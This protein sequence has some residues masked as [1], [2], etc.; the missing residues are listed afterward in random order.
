MIKSN[1]TAINARI[2]NITGNLAIVDSTLGLILTD[3][4]T[5]RLRVVAINET[6][7]IIQTALGK[8]N[9]TIISVEGDMATIVI[10]EIGRI[11][12]D[13]S[14]LKEAQATS[15][16][17]QYITIIIALIA[18]IT[19]TLSVILLKGKKATKTG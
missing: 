12:A 8:M 15:V 1:L 13:V 19:S 6:T 3:L 18:A 16:I 5:I 17:P 7:V 9:G 14:D 2:I 4:D 11:K 10:P